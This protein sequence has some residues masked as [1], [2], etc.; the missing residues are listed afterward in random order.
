MGKELITGNKG[1]EHD[2]VEE[3]L[4]DLETA[5]EVTDKFG[6]PL[7]RYTFRGKVVIEPHGSL[8]EAQSI[9]GSL[10][11]HYNVNHLE[12]EYV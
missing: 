6:A 4:S 9:V 2:N 1:C 3:F 11:K 5:G 7:T 8:E 10:K 12:A